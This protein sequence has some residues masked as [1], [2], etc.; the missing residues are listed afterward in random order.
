M[1][2]TN[3]EGGEG[4]GGECSGKERSSFALPS[5]RI[6]TLPTLG[7]LDQANYHPAVAAAAVAV[8]PAHVALPST[9]QP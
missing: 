4:G 1:H 9:P 7:M 2:P 8:V 5:M 6:T 3:G